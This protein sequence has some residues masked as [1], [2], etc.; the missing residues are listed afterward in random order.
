MKE[1]DEFADFLGISFRK[2]KAPEKSEA[3]KLQDARVSGEVERMK[4]G[5]DEAP[6]QTNYLPFALIGL[7]VMVVFFL[8]KKKAGK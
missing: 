8:I 3:E 4:L 5:L 1:F 2:K 6:V 7:V